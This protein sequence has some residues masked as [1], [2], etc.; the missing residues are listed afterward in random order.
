MLRARGP[1]R[2]VQCK[3]TF[4]FLFSFVLTRL[5]LAVRPEQ[6][7]VLIPVLP[8]LCLGTFDVQAAV[9]QLCQGTLPSSS[10]EHESPGKGRFSLLA[11][12]LLAPQRT[13]EP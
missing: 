5:A 13:A 1:T 4:F 2:N 3:K 7:G 10:P 8:V 12:H 6:L 11:S 9:A